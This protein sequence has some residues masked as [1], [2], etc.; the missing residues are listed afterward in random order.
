LSGA[1][2]VKYTGFADQGFHCLTDSENVDTMITREDA[3]RKQCKPDFKRTAM[4]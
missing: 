3:L 2:K 4:K 1:N